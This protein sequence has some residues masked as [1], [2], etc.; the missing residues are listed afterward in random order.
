MTQEKTHE[1]VRSRN[2]A[3][4][5]RTATR[6]WHEE[7]SED[8]P[9]IAASALCHGYDLFELMEKRSF[10]EVFYLLFRGELGCRRKHWSRHAPRLD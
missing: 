1:K 2:E 9:Y 8:N 7:P 10:V 5:Q 4:T 6:I 3:F